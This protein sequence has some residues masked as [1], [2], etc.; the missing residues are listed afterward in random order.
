MK[1][2]ILLLFAFL[3]AAQLPAQ[4]ITNQPMSQV[5]VSGDT[6]TL[7]VA[8][9]GAEIPAYQWRCNGTNITGETGATLTIAGM[10]V[11]QSGR[12]DVVVSNSLGVVTSAVARVTAINVTK[13]WTGG[14]DGVSWTD[15]NNWNGGTLPTSADSIL[16][17]SGTNTI[18]SFSGGTLN[19][20]V[21][22]C[23][24]T[25]N[26][27]LTVVG[28]VQI[29]Q[30]IY[31]SGITVATGGT[32]ALFIDLGVTSLTTVTLSA[33][34]GGALNFQALTTLAS[35]NNSSCTLQ[36][37]GEGSLL[38][39]PA[40]KTI[41]GPQNANAW[42]NIQA[43]QGGRLNLS[44]V[45]AMYCYY[46]YDN[47]YGADGIVINADGTNSVIDLTG[48]QSFVGTS[49][50]TWAAGSGSYMQPSNG[51]Q[52]LVPN[53]TYVKGLSLYVAGGMTFSLPALATY[54]IDG[55]AS[56]TLQATGAGSLLDLPALK[57]INGPYYALSWLSLQAS[58]GGR[59]NL[60]GVNAM[61]CYYYYDNMYGADGIVI[62]ADGT[63]S[64]I[65][66]T[67]L[68]SFMGY[69]RDTWAAAAGSYMQPSNGGQILVPNLGNVKGLSLYVA[70]GM[71]FS[72]PALTNCSSSGSSITLQSSGIGSVLVLTNLLLFS[73]PGSLIQVDGGIILT[74][75]NTIYQNVTI[76]LS[77]AILVQPQNI[78]TQ[79]NSA[80]T[81]S[82]GIS[83]GQPLFYQW[84]F[85][86]IPIAN[87]TNVS[88]GISSVTAG[89]A[90]NYSVAVTNVYG[91]VTSSPATLT[92]IW[93][94]TI[95]MQ[96]MN[97]TTGAGG[98]VTFTIQVSAYPAPTYQWRLNGTNISGA[99]GSSY[100]IPSASYADA[101]YYDV[102]VANTAGT[103]VSSPASLAI[104]DIKMYAGIN[105]YG[106][107]GASYS[108]Q[109]VSALVGTNWNVLTNVALP[110]Q[111]YIYID[112]SSP[113]NGQQFYRAVPQ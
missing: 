78:I 95:T 69:S 70:G 52:I 96:P 22:Q 67:G 11:A 39:L 62:N 26:G 34:N 71:T 5:L 68:R 81:F 43:L 30:G 1:K 61:Y 23:P 38:N 106:P 33:Q 80:V 94:P 7:S 18:S 16:I 98:I 59:L 45:N 109:A 20:M 17:G 51:G 40:L 50:E 27:S 29:V 103:N 14:G 110:S 113:T 53:L 82:V 32:N 41:N 77:P 85:N 9:S 88:Y 10:T 25:I 6:A 3:L 48:L 73:G 31:S 79:I 4:T 12:Y 84:F 104:V 111:P 108:L 49:R 42:L 74:N 47:M 102:V 83:G 72:L 76:Q 105:V 107:L 86:C 44:G 36:A 24:I 28:A 92:V 57:T 90:G 35:G 91:S 112:Y 56:C 19:N 100:T 55:L 66:L 97:Q 75:P 63:N 89:D 54:A 13:Q 15:A 37:T 65:D 87:A 64:V 60:S 46:Y 2:K 58:Q 101:G 99:T 21:C 93:P 8:V